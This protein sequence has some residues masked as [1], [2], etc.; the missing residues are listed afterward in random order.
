MTTTTDDLSLAADF[1]ASTYEDGLQLVD[2]RANER[3]R[4]KSW[5]QDPMTAEDRAD[6]SAAT[7][8]TRSP[9][10][11]RVRPGRSA[12]GPPKLEGGA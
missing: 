12:S 8:A 9:T 1:C 6:R 5:S 10:T 11:A 2:G 7:N 3:A 4:S